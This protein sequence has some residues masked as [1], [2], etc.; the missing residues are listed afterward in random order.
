MNFKAEEWTFFG[1]KHLAPAGPGSLKMHAGNAR[2]N[3]AAVTLDTRANKTAVTLEE[4]EQIKVSWV[5]VSMPPLGHLIMC[6][7]AEGSKIV[8]WANGSLGLVK[9]VQT[10]KPKLPRGKPVL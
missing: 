9:T 4:E 6:S 7:G 5:S 1:Y 3:K 10:E 8:A 2:S